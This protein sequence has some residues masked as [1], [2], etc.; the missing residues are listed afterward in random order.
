MYMYPVFAA[1][2]VGFNTRFAALVLVNKPERF[3]V[4]LYNFEAKPQEGAIRVWALEPGS[5][6]VTTGVD[7]AGDDRIHESAR[8][9]Q[10]ELWRGAAVPVSLPSRQV[11]IV[12]ARQRSRAKPLMERPDVGVVTEDAE[13]DVED[14]VLTVK[15][16]NIGCVPVTD[17]QVALRDQNGETQA[18]GT[19][20]SLRAP[21]DFVPKVAEVK[22]DDMRR[23]VSQR[24]TVELGP[25]HGLLEITRANNTIRLEIDESNPRREDS[26]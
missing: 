22:F 13:W 17:L 4:A 3:K 6:E 11:L 21:L 5:Y 16:H 7:T 15:V 24:V 18:V 26:Q 8:T 1:S 2:Y 25:D 9:S 10:T 20:S 19:V 12:D 23:L 14:G